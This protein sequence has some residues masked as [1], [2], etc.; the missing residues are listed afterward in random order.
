MFLILLLTGLCLPSTSFPY[1]YYFVR[2]AM[3]WYE[4]YFYCISEHTDMASIRSVDDLT[5]LMDTPTAGY[6][7]KAW[8][9]LYENVS[10]WVWVDGQPATYS[11]WRAGQPDDT[12]QADVCACITDQGT[13]W[14]HRCSVKKAAVCFNENNQS[15]ILVGTP[16]TWT[17]AKSYCED[18]YLMLASVPDAETNELIQVMLGPDMQAWIGLSGLKLWYWT[19]TGE[20]YTN[21]T[22][23]QPE[24]PDNLNG[25]EKCAAALGDGSWADEQCNMIYPFF[26]YGV[27]K[28]RKTWVRMKIQSSANMDDPACSAS[29]EQQLR[30][31]LVS[32]GVTDFKLAWKKLPVKKTR[33]QCSLTLKSDMDFYV[34]LILLLFGFSFCSCSQVPL[35]T[36]YYVNLKMTW[37]DA[38]HYCR[39][40]YTDLATIESMDD[41]SR[42]KPD[43]SYSWA[44]I[45]LKDDP[46]SWNKV[47]GNDANSW[48]WSATGETSKTDYQNW[49]VHEPNNLYANESCVLMGSDGEWSDAKCQSLRSFVCYTDSTGL[50]SSP[51]IAVTKQGEKTYVFISYSKTW[52]SAQAYCR[53]HHTDLPTIE[54]EEDNSEVYHAKPAEAVVWIGLHRVPWTWSDESP[55]SFRNWRGNSPNNYLGTQSCMTE[56]PQHDWDDDN[57]NSEF[58]F[59]CHQVSKRKT[60]VRMKIETD[61]DITDPVTNAQILQLLGAALTSRGWTTFNLQ[62]KIQPG[63]QDK[64]KLTKPFCL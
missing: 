46:K 49:D 43:F 26:C 35:R 13:W 32:K 21:F 31:A 19:D 59:I 40:N 16:M 17:E 18:N 64:E 63:K 55:S 36:Y 24:Q 48:R 61:A 56:S 52:S 20:N 28:S 2:E 45:G 7:D 27:Y 60:T 15:Y 29:L 47:M 51:S 4:A 33:G 11:N 53:E 8:I 5:A 14:D 22:N 62:W 25:E 58:P 1:V 57:C 44:W 9:G 23:W 37:N 3:S 6:T 50:S 34:T 10:D 12:R 41:I 38:Q 30:A 54:N 39:V 42:L